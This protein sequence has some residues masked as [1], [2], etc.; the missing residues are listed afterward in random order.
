M[1]NSL[2]KHELVLLKT[3]QEAP[4]IKSFYF[5]PAEGRFDYKPGQVLSIILD[6]L[7][8]AELAREFSI[9]S[10]PTEDFI[11]ISMRMLVGSK[12]KSYINCL[13]P[14]AKILAEGPYGDFTLPEDTSRPLLFIAG[15]IGVTPFR[16]MMK[17]VADMAL[18]FTVTLLYSARTPEEILYKNDWQTFRKT[19][20]GFNAIFTITRPEESSSKWEGR[21]GRIDQALIEESVENLSE[22]VTYV[23]GTPEMVR[24]MM[25]ILVG[26][27]LPPQ[28]LKVE[29]FSGYK[30]SD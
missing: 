18:P 2:T 28:K 21:V 23:C 6:P 9:A 4:E 20:K 8:P 15:G 30:G 16:G 25:K 19:C 10:S 29:P 1:S 24:S 27:G 7:R 12:F 13:S 17:Y 14:G 3:A 11:L 5:E 26:M 22:S